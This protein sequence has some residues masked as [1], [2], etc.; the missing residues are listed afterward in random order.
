MSRMLKKFIRP[1]AID[2][3]KI[4][5]LNSEALR[6]SAADGVSVI[7][8]L[9][10]N[11]SDVPEFLT[12]PIATQDPTDAQHLARKGYVDQ[13]IADLIGAAPA[14]LDTLQ[15]LAA[16]LG[17][18]ENFATSLATQLGAIRDRLDTLEGGVSV[19]GS[20]AKAAKDALDAAKAYTDDE[21]LLDRNRL[22]TLEGADTVAGS[23]AKAAKDALDAAKSY[24]DGVE[25]RLDDRLDI[26]EGIGEGSVAKAEADA[27]AYADTI[28]TA[29]DDRLD[30]L[31]GS[32]EGSV[33][34]AEADAV[35]HADGLNTA[36]DT[37][38]DSI[39]ALAFHKEKKVIGQMEVM[40]GYVDLA[41]EAV[42]NSTFIFVQG[43]GYLYEGDD[44]SLSVVGEVSRVTLLGDFAAGGVTA[45]ENGDVL[46]CQYQYDSVGSGGNSGGGG[47]GLAPNL[48]LMSAFESGSNY[49]IYWSVTNPGT[50][51]VAVVVSG[52]GWTLV[53]GAGLASAGYGQVDKALLTNGNSY[54]LKLYTD[55]Y[56]T[57][58]V[59][60]QVIS[61]QSFTASISSGGGPTTI[62]GGM[63]P[64]TVMGSNASLTWTIANAASY[65]FV[66]LFEV[67]GMVPFQSFTKV[68]QLNSASAGAGIVALSAL[69]PA[70]SYVAGLQALEADLTP[71][72]WTGSF[73]VSQ[74]TG[75]TPPALPRI[76]SASFGALSTV[77]GVDKIAVNWTHSDTGGM[78]QAILQYYNPANG[79][80]WAAGVLLG[81]ITADT[82]LV[83]VSSLVDAGHYRVAPVPNPI[84]LTA[85]GY[86]CVDFIYTATPAFNINGT[87]V[88]QNEF[89]TVSDFGFLT[90]IKRAEDRTAP[91]YCQL[92]S[93]NVQFKFLNIVNA[94]GNGGS[95]EMQSG[96]S[97]ADLSA[98][99][100]SGT[101]PAGLQEYS[102][103]DSGNTLYNQGGAASWLIATNTNAQ[104]Y[105]GDV[106]K[107]R[108]IYSGYMFVKIVSVTN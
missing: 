45:L 61:A 48:D 46:A 33:A 25:T 107:L 67:T 17:N 53:A 105:E 99:I 62:T 47:G 41:H 73:Q 10:V 98:W 14:L 29:L 35:A 95:A 64:Y 94:P 23:V 58:A 30:V 7:S 84:D 74:G 36:M 88:T 49:S 103:N 21:V 2:G 40:Q 50:T 96:P 6:A 27:K 66:A 9:K 85:F 76:D 8:I 57:T 38:V 93:T 77:M 12:L 83:D 90:L 82:A 55:M 15:E 3:S 91:N 11:A 101:V 97:D 34:K 60:P 22:D 70:K 75:G 32:G 100:V 24:A 108:S 4:K 19:E 43:G 16:A 56:L 92:T 18:D 106:V 86:P 68:Q 81:N 28:Q 78:Q 69:D 102:R 13:K 54:R 80:D 44:Y 26:I 59:D 72:Y 39:E 89:S 71:S 52:P 37:R 42:A 87:G 63:P 1:D 5:L 20:V 51:Y 65:P 79:G 104:W 31:E